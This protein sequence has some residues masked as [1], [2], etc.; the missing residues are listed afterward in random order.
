MEFD[1]PVVSSTLSLSGR[2]FGKLILRAESVAAGALKYTAA[3]TMGVK[4]RGDW[5]IWPWR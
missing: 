3:G 2:T 1:V 4:I 5:E